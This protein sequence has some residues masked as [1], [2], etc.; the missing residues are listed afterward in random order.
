[1]FEYQTSGWSLVADVPA[2]ESRI[3]EAAS[4]GPALVSLIFSRREITRG[5]N[6]GRAYTRASIRIHGPAN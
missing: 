2:I 1:M 6:K 4:D 5:P 3:A